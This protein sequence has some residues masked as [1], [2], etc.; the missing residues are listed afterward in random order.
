[1]QLPVAQTVN[2]WSLGANKVNGGH[3]YVRPLYQYK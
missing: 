1:M 2:D 3:M